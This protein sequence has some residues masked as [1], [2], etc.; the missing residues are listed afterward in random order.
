MFDIIEQQFKGSEID[1]LFSGS[2]RYFVVSC[3]SAESVQPGESA[4][5]HPSKRFWR[6]SICS[7]W[8]GTDLDVDVE[9]TLYVINN[10][11]TVSAVDKSFSDRRPYIGNLFTHRRCEPGIMYAGTAD[12]S[13]E[14]EPVAVNSNIAFYAFHLFIGI[15]TIITLAIA[16]LDALSVKCHHRR[17]G[18]LTAFATYL[19]DEFLD[20][21][22]QIPLRP[23]FVEVPIHGLPFGKIVWK[24]TPLAYAG[25]QVQ[26]CLE[27]G[28]QGIFAMS[29]I[30]FK[31][32]FVYIR[33][34]T[35]GQMCLIEAVFMHSN[36][37]SSTNTL[38]EGL[39]CPILFNLV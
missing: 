3:E 39:L 22:I 26:D 30:I 27:Y 18:G 37:F 13:A 23:P 2:G 6:K 31:E 21:V 1:H 9:I 28:A 12:I 33:P 24:H 38:I 14:D 34:L 16:P 17:C 5:H 35:L 10:L 25:Q 32:Y 20:T 19:H 8:S 11:T 7:V 15:E 4:F 29:A 36:L